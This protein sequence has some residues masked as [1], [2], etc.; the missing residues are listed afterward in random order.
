MPMNTTLVIAARRRARH[1]ASSR[2][3][4]HTWPTIS[5][6]LRLR[7]KPCCAVEQNEQSMRAA[8]LRGDAQRAAVGLR[9]VDHLDALHAR[10]CAASTCA[11]RPPTAAPSTISGTATVARTRPAARGT[12]CARSRHRREV[13]RTA[14]VDPLH[15]LARAERLR[16]E[17]LGDERL[18]LGARQAEQIDGIAGHFAACPPIVLGATLARTRADLNFA[19]EIRDLAGRRVGRI[20]AVHHVLVDAAARGPRGSCPAPPSS[21]PSRP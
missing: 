10:P 15:Q 5:A 3:A 19:E 7:L 14:P 21:D 11:C 8:D 2:C 16:A 17:A 20:R 18:E 9:D 4:S 1:H 12:P 6:T 13:R